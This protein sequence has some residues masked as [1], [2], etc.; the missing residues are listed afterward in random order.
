MAGRQRRG[1][2]G[3][4]TSHASRP[5]RR[6][7]PGAARAGVLTVTAALTVSLLPLP[8]VAQDV[9]DLPLDVDALSD[10]LQLRRGL[11][12]VLDP[13][14]DTLA[15]DGCDELDPARCLLPFPNDRFTAPASTP[16]GIRVDLSPL[17]TPRQTAGLPIRTTE[18]NRN[19]GWSPGAAALT[20]VP[21]L[22]LQRTFGIDGDQLTRPELS[23]APD[24]PIVVLDA[25]TG[26][27]VPYWAELDTHPDTRDQERLLIVR[28]LT[29]YAHGHRIVVGLRDLR[30]ADGQPIASSDGFRDQLARAASD[31]A[32]SGDPRVDGDARYRRLLGDLASA[33]VASDDLV[34]AWDF[35]I[36]SRENLTGRALHIR[37][38]AFAQLGDT[39]LADGEVQGRSP[40]FA[41]DEVAQVAEGPTARVVRGRLTVPN[42]LTLPPNELPQRP[43]RTGLIPAD[44]PSI[45]LPVTS[46]V[47]PSLTPGPMTLPQ[48]NSVATTAEVP[49]TC[50]VP[51]EAVE[52]GQ[53]ALPTLYGHGLL[54]SHEEVTGSSTDRM[55]RDNFLVCAT[56]WTGMSFG[57][58]P[59]V[60]TILADASNMGT[61]ADRSQQGFLHFLLL[62]RAMIHPEGLSQH[63]AF[64][65]DGRSVIDTTELFYDGNSQGG[66]LGGALTALSPDFTKA[67]LGVPAMN[68]S[69]LL[70][71][72]VDWEGAYGDILYLFY[73]DKRDQQLVLGLIQM[74]WDRGEANGYAHHMTD[75]PLPNTPPHQVLLHVAFADHQVTNV[76]A[77]VQARTVGA[78]VLQTALAPGRHWEVHPYFGL[79][80]FDVDEV[81]RLEPHAGSALVY[82]D[83]G[84]ATPPNG[85]VPATDSS[86]PH[87]DPRRDD[88][89]QVQ[90]R[91]FYTTGDVIDVWGG[92]PYW[93]CEVRG[94]VNPRRC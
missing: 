88:R 54:G 2:T 10:S 27:R 89:G 94:P 40:R 72:S 61:L 81:G 7:R 14:F 11:T 69:T 77:E 71:R 44:V 53:L 24:A 32:A 5:G 86:D 84:N 80:G 92:Q 67:T 85:N 31:D 66:I 83:S 13:V 57:D 39:D 29:N 91:V 45:L 74:L 36:A 28:P 8:V 78:R 23:L 42:F 58:I 18:F 50:A 34:L 30:D 64:Q 17:A 62:G 41:V 37:D 20:R 55:R 4:A 93:T 6:R 38:L 79:D 52:T 63:P 46:F 75:D 35:T 51:R 82:F 73:P 19:D 1:D 33:G 21:G 22:D 59:N 25:T 12:A 43:D 60:A 47:Y 26:Q 3:R 65:V 15:G 70:N 68:Y 16:T 56:P 48:Q 49:F 76:A 9:P 90:K 87:S